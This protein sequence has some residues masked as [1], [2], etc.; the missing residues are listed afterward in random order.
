MIHKG[1][2]DGTIYHNPANRFCIISV[3]TADKEVPLEARSTRRYRDHLIRFVATGY[4]LPRTDAVELELDG[5][6][7]QGKYGMQFQ[8]EQWRQIVPRTKSGVEGYLASGL[9]KGIGP[10]TATLIVSRFGEDTLDILQKRPERLLEIKGITESKLEEI[11]TSYAESR[12]LQDLLVLL[13]PFKITPK[14]ALKIYQYFGPAS[15]D[16]LKKSPFELC[17]ISG[18][19]FLRVDAIVQKNGGDLHDPMRVKGALFW[20]L[21]DGN[22]GVLE[23]FIRTYT[24]QVKACRSKAD[25]VLRT[26]VKLPCMNMKQ[27]SREFAV[28]TAAGYGADEIIL[29][30]SLAMWMDR[31]SYRLSSNSIPAEKLAAA[32]CKMLLNCPEALPDSLYGY[33]GWLFTRYKDFSIKYEGNRDLWEAV[34]S[35][36]SPSSPKTIL[37][38]NQNIKQSFNYRFDVFD[39]QYDCLAVELKRDTYLELFTMQMLRSL[40][41][42][43]TGQWLARYKQ[44]TGADYMEYFTCFRQ[45]TEEAFTLLV[46]TKKIDLWAFFEKH[47]A[48]GEYAYPLKL[49]RDYAL[50]ISSW[51]CY[52]FVEKLLN[53]YRFTQLQEIFG[54]RFYFHRS[55]CE[56]TGGYGNE[57]FRTIIARPFLGP[58]EHRKLYEW[59]DSSFFQMEPEHYTAFVWSALKDP[60]IQ[61]LYDRPTLASVLRQLIARGNSGGYDGNCLKKRFYSKKELEADRKAAAEK[62]E[63]E[64]MLQKQQEFLKRKE[65]LEQIYNGSA[66]SLVQFADKYY[67]KEDKQQAMNMVYEKLLEW[68]AGCVQELTPIDTQNFFVLCGMLAKYETR[69]KQELL[70]MVKNMIEGGAAA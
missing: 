23:W 21:E 41:S 49:L 35:S 14:T 31:I 7:K 45:H 70:D 34:N 12:M 32:C 8:V 65:K 39:P 4:E 61:R 47:R 19:G 56:N 68:P 53:Q 62:K 37:W 5:E 6:W 3:K 54:D 16:I 22:C 57:N 43:T 60:T 36:L 26:L 29:A 17:Q 69:P 2:Y 50:R 20:A 10:A 44:L 25:L 52:R 33:V 24:E 18:F 27:D 63:Q 42:A 48:E 30:N 51:K 28:L 38:M 66:M 55:F 64:Q 58:E 11:K 67:Y 1:T 9:I 46:E 40:G 13:S 15:V 59:V